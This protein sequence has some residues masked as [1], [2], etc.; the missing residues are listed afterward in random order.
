M[1]KHIVGKFRVVFLNKYRSKSNYLSFFNSR[2][3]KLWGPFQHLSI[4]QTIVGTTLDITH[5]SGDKLRV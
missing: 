3:N 1:L 4:H 5:L 2:A